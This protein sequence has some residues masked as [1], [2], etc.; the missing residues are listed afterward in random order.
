MEGKMDFSNIVFYDGPSLITCIC[1][2][3]LIIIPIIS[4]IVFIN[5]WIK[6][7][8][9][10]ELSW[11]PRIL[12]LNILFV[13]ASTAFEIV[14]KIHFIFFYKATN[15]SG[16]AQ[17]CIIF[18]EIAHTCLFIMFAIPVLTFCIALVILLPKIIKRNIEANQTP[19]G[20]PAPPSS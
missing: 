10:K 16:A 14:Y 13:I 3:F 8:R 9:G 12:Y 6:K 17:T 7:R 11:Q 20:N 2:S 1:F 18:M 19:S 5:A 15:E 4:L